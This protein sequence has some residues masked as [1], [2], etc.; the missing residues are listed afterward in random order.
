MANIDPLIWSGRPSREGA[1]PIRLP[2]D[3]FVPIRPKISVIV[4]NHGIMQ[5]KAF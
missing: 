1:I 2:T 5:K 3:M 4:N